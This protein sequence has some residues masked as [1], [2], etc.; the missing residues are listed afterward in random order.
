MTSP[1]GKVLAVDPG[2]VRIGLAISDV[3]RS[4]ARPLSVL[5]HIQRDQDAAKIAEIA[6]RNECQ[7]I[8]IGQALDTNDKPNLS[9][10]KS[11]RLATAVREHTSLDVILWDESHTTQRAHQIRRELSRSSGEIDAQAAALI[12]QDYLDSNKE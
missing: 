10:R 7:L 1:D 8:V 11:R 3:T 9:G 12:L 4:L 2:D 6:A 5:K